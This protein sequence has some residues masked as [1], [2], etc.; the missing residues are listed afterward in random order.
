MACGCHNNV[1]NFSHECSWYNGMTSAP[2][3]AH[4]LVKHF[5]VVPLNEKTSSNKTMIILY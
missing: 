3:Y 1:V 4:L 5:V 2:F